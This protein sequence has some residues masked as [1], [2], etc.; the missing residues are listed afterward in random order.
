MIFSFDGTS[1]HFEGCMLGK[2]VTCL[3]RE[4]GSILFKSYTLVGE[5][6]TPAM[7]AVVTDSSLLE[8]FHFSGG[9]R[10]HEN[11]RVV[12]EF[13]FICREWRHVG[14]DLFGDAAATLNSIVSNSYYEMLSKYIRSYLL[15]IP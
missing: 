12:D 15:S 14:M 10:E 7:S 13:S 2:T 5:S 8:N 11:A 3:K 6:T 1:A 9:R 4:V